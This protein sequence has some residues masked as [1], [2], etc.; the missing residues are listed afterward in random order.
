M[1]LGMNH[2]CFSKTSKERRSVFRQEFHKGITKD[3]YC[4]KA[5]WCVWF[6][7]VE[8]SIEKSFYRKFFARGIDR[9]PSK[10]EEVIEEEQDFLEIRQANPN[11]GKEF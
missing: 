9:L 8:S 2:S 4:K 6:N 1:S 11:A 5:M 3:V 7:K 10:E